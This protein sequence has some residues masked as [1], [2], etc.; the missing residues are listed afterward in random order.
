[1]QID[2]SDKTV[3]ITGAT[4][5]IGASIARDFGHLGATLILTGTKPDHIESLNLTNK[6][7]G[8]ISVRYCHLD[9]LDE[10]SVFTFINDIERE[11][12][13]DICINN[14]GINRLNPIDKVLIE[15]L[16]ALLSV[17]LRGPFMISRT[18]S[19]KM[20]QANYGRIVNIAS[21]WSV[22]TKP[23]R[24]VYTTTKFGIVGMTKSLAVDLG[25]FNILVNSVSPGFVS[26]ELTASTLSPL[27]QESLANQIPIKRFAQPD[28]ISKLVLFLA[29]DLNTY[30][31]GQNIIID[32]GFTNV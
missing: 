27:E 22:I 19:R 6:K 5:G 12:R 32:G 20:K 10:K 31:T 1:M 28:E 25:P 2:F 13:I 18:V 29:S 14:A 16:D 9:F 11:H 4:R 26:T 3:L 23:Q 8:N 24:S 21:I 15:D 30:I 7:I 17:N